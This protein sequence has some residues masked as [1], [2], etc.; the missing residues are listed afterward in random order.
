MGKPPSLQAEGCPTPSFKDTLT[1]VRDAGVLFENQDIPCRWHK[2]THMV[3]QI[4]KETQGGKYIEQ[5]RLKSGLNLNLKIRQ[6][7]VYMWVQE[8]A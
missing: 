5:H 3:W 7:I 4:G 8:R 1:S 6:K 2:H